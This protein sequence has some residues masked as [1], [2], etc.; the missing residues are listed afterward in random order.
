[1]SISSLNSIEKKWLIDELIQLGAIKIGD[2]TLKSGQKSNLYFDLRLI[3]SSPH[4]LNEVVEMFAN[5]YSH[6]NSHD[7][8]HNSFYDLVCGVPSAGIP[9]ATAFS[10][11]TETPMILV[12]KEPKGYGTGQLI[13]GIW[14]SGD[15]VFLIEDVMTTGSSTLEI[16]EILEKEKLHVDSVGVLIDRRTQNIKNDMMHIDVYSLLTINDIEEYL[17]L[18]AFKDSSENILN[19]MLE[20]QFTNPLATYLWDIVIKKQTNL[21][22]SIDVTNSSEILPLIELVGDHICLLKIHYDIFPYNEMITISSKINKL[23]EEKNFLILNDRKYA[24]IGSVIQRQI[25]IEQKSFGNFHAVTAHS[26]F[27]NESL[28][29]LTDSKVDIFLVAQSSSL[30]NLISDNYSKKTIK[31]GHLAKVPGFICQNRIEL[32]NNYNHN[33]YTYNPEN[34]LHLTPGVNLNLSAD[35]LGQMY[36]TPEEAIV[37]DK[38]DIIIVGRGIYASSNIEDTI[39][40]YKTEGWYALIKRYTK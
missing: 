23:A 28:N 16:I 22:L 31:N 30:N 11:K 6:N 38:C 5:L 7:Y 40:Q 17:K 4:L 2:F 1:M 12:R 34:F 27:G 15:K 25:D 36:R 10:I 18:N 39:K 20:R 37:R 21:C 29:G 24:D 32:D 19:T 8:A 35:K 3:Y 13:E 14:K 26:L 9:Y 33:Q